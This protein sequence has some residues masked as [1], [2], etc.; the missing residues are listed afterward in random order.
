MEKF[1]PIAG[2]PKGSIIS[3]QICNCVLDGLESFCRKGLPKTYNLDSGE[4]KRSNGLKIPIALSRKVSISFIRFED[5][6]LVIGKSSTEV[7][8]VIRNR[9]KVFLFKLG[10]DIK[11]NS[12]GII[13]F[14]PGISFDYLGFRF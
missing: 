1:T 10:L 14:S 8:Q 9:L 13:N 3:P 5:A 2:V 6:I 12:E 11:A 7:F 4:I